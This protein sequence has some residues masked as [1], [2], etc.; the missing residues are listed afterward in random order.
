MHRIAILLT[1]SYRTRPLPPPRMNFDQAITQDSRHSL[2]HNPVALFTVLA[3]RE[4]FE[5]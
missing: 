4:V 5:V 1:S 3:Q 2:L